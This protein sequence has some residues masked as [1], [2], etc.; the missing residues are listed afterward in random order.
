MRNWQLAR[1]GAV[2]PPVH[3]RYDME[4]AFSRGLYTGWFHG[5]NNQQ[6]VH[7]RFGKKRGV[8]LGEV[9][10]IEGE[11]VCVKPARPR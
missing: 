2:L 7:G 1:R 10:R 3:D 5:T 4:M 11:R 6:L 9:S 8:F